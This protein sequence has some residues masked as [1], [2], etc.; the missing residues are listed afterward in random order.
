MSPTDKHRA[1]LLALPPSG[2]PHRALGHQPSWFRPLTLAGLLELLAL[3]PQAR[4]IQSNKDFNQQARDHALCDMSLAESTVAS[5]LP[6][7]TWFVTDRPH[8]CRYLAWLQARLGES[9]L[10][11]PNLVPE[12]LVLREEEDGEAAG[13]VRLG[14]A[15]L[16]ADLLS[17]LGEQNK[18]PKTKLHAP[19]LAA[20]AGQIQAFGGERNSGPGLTRH[21]ELLAFET[22]VPHG[23]PPVPPP[24]PRSTPA[25]GPQ[26]L[27]TTTL[28]SHVL[29][30][31]ATPPFP[32]ADN[33]SGPPRFDLLP[34]LIAAQATAV[35]ASRD[36][37][38][39]GLKHREVLL[40]QLLLEQQT[41]P[42]VGS[43]V[44]SGQATRRGTGISDPP[45]GLLDAAAAGRGERA[46][47]AG[48]GGAARPGDD[49]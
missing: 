39:G 8:C 38:G 14:A 49:R 32:Y 30:A 23:L 48:G 10:V 7:E 44:C 19:A 18:K 1:R 2:P 45:Y 46:R 40:E 6:A 36:R 34:V 5:P 15:V 42:T 24:W 37:R 12:L 20:L 43:Q 4:L 22:G 17:F 25:S 21:R 11:S 35:L 31:L 41:A 26:R 29:Q 27:N 28:G 47:G 9:I 3:H 16:L 13:C 33:P